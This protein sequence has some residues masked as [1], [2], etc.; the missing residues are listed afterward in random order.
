L[1]RSVLLLL[2]LLVCPAVASARPAPVAGSFEVALAPT[3]MMG[4]QGDR[5]VREGDD[6]VACSLL[7]GFAADLSG[8]VFVSESLRLG[9]RSLFL[10]MLGRSDESGWLVQLAAEARL[11]PLPI[12]AEYLWLGLSM[13]ALMARDAVHYGGREM[14]AV[15]TVMPDLGAAVG[16][17]FS[18]SERFSLGVLFRTDLA[19]GPGPVLP[20]PGEPAY[21]TQVLLSGGASFTLRL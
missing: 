6:V 13:G 8:G 21:D 9:L 10:P 4:V 11:R 18:L 7:G 3:L 1:S 14:P 19:F 2:P 17:D 15:V 16:Y 5:C 20:R 12:S